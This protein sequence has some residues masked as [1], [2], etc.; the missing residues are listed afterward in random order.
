MREKY[1]VPTIEEFYVGFEYEVR[2]LDGSGY[3]TNEYCT[4]EF[5][6]TDFFNKYD[7]FV[8]N[9]WVDLDKIRVKYLDQEDIESLGFIKLPTLDNH[10]RL[11]IKKDIGLNSIVHLHLRESNEIPFPISIW[12]GSDENEED[13]ITIP[14]IYIK[15]KSELKKLLK[16]LGL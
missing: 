4:F 11:L 5:D 13:Y 8:F 12:V 3:Y 7:E 6:G 2:Q 14:T 10:F 9:D 1:Y 16:Q 15:N